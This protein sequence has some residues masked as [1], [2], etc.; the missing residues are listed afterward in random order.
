[1]GRGVVA[2]L[3]EPA[4]WGANSASITK[5]YQPR[6]FWLDALEYKGGVVHLEPYYVQTTGGDIVRFKLYTTPIMD[7]AWG[8]LLWTSA[9]LASNT[10]QYKDY[11]FQDT[12]LRQIERFLYWVLEVTGSAGVWSVHFRAF[13][14][15]KD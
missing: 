7:T 8:T 13:M 6:E 15:L 2:F 3:Q 14:T 5:V 10:K 1:M 9:T 4:T 12:S 11:N